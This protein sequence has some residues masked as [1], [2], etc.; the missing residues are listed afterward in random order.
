MR[1]SIGTSMKLAYLAPQSHG[2]SA[3][4]TTSSCPWIP[5]VA[6]VDEHADAEGKERVIKGGKRARVRR[7]VPQ[8][9]PELA[10]L[11]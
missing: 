2:S 5:R 9:T 6:R 4:A 7:G 10:Q 11:E 3:S 1:T 8:R